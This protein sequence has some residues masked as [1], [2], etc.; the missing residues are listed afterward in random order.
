[1]H[2]CKYSYCQFPNCNGEDCGVPAP[3]LLAEAC[4]EANHWR[5]VAEHM[6]HVAAGT[7]LANVLDELNRLRPQAFSPICGYGY[8]NCANDPAYLRACD[9]DRW[10]ELGRPIGC[11]E[12]TEEECPYFVGR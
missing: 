5:Q 6:Y 10:V 11:C 9:P 8:I 7:P 4:A 3:D 1:M 12:P 2:R